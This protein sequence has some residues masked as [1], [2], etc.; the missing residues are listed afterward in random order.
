MRLV[1]AGNILMLAD[2][3]MTGQVYTITKTEMK[4]ATNLF[5][6]NFEKMPFCKAYNHEAIQSTG[7]KFN[8]ALI[9]HIP[10]MSA[11]FCSHL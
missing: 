2:P 8:E 4:T 3:K 1:H 9:S 7:L 5:T 11:K 10:Y 6:A